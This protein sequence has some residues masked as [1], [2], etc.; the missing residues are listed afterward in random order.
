MT[1]FIKWLL[2]IS[3]VIFFILMLAFIAFG[4]IDEL[5]G[6]AQAKKLLKKLN[7]PLSYSQI[8]ILG[9]ICLVICMTLYYLRRRLFTK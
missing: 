3:C 6:P 5:F 9:I 1:N 4:I 7:I 8:I 2:N